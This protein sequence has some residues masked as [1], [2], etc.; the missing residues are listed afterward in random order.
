MGLVVRSEKVT[1]AKKL[2]TVSAVFGIA[3]VSISGQQN[4]VYASAQAA[5]GRTA[6]QASCDMPDLGGRNEAPPLAGANFKNTWRSRTTKDLFE[7]MG[8]MP[9]DAPSLATDQYL[10][11]AALVLQSN[12]APAGTQPFTPGTAVPI[13]TVATGA[14]AA[15]TGPDISQPVRAGAAPVGGGAQTAGRARG[16]RGGGADDDI[17]A[18]RGGGRAGQGGGVVGIT[19][20]GEVKN[21]VPVTDEMLRN[22]DPG[23]WLMARRN[24]Q[25]WSYSP[26][27]RTSRARTSRSCSSP[28]CGR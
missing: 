9:P 20:A 10:A 22:P 4:P 3:V 12:G 23:D 15:A 8:T 19:L 24:Y 14:A 7:Y 16:Q 17:P 1:A 13:G 27:S 21:D 28:G 5:A 25:G 26:R 6:Y 2:A 18:G 11:I